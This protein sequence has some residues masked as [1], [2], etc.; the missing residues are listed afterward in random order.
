MCIRIALQEE[1]NRMS[2][3]A[4]AIVFAP[5]ILR[6][7]DTI[8]P[9]QS[10]QDIS[11]TTAYGCQLFINL[12]SSSYWLAA[13]KHKFLIALEWSSG[14]G[15]FFGSIFCIIV[16]CISIPRC[17]IHLTQPA[18]SCYPQIDNTDF[19]S[20]L[21]IVTDMVTELHF[22]CFFPLLCCCCCIVG[23][24]CQCSVQCLHTVI[25]I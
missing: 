19:Q 6:C 5:C 1:T 10:V 16:S 17:F 18:L 25:F 21:L 8:D 4:L 14:L 3:N 22:H 24:L 13:N 12:C 7:P 15:Q 2:A 23:N 20:P 11:K 9:L